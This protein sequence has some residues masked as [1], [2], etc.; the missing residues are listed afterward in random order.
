MQRRSGFTLIEVLVT[1][2]IVAILASIA[3]PLYTDYVRRGKITEATSNLLAMRTK[4]EQFYQDNRSYNPGGAIP[5]P[6]AAGSSIQPP[7]M[8]GFTIPAANCVTTATTY[9]ITADGGVAGGDQSLVGIHYSI[10]QSNNRLTT[11]DAGSTMANAGYS[12][13]ANCWVSKKP[14]IC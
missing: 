7:T 2:A 3:L 11:V 9:T 8:K 1:V 6:C 4:M 13:S 10:D 14:N 12:S 5:A